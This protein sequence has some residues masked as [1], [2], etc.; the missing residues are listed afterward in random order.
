[1]P[2]PAERVEELR[3]ALE[4]GL[5]VLLAAPPSRCKGLAAALLDRVESACDAT[6]R[7]ALAAWSGRDH[8]VEPLAIAA[9]VAAALHAPSDVRTLLDL[10]GCTDGG[11]VCV[12]DAGH[13][14]REEL[15]PWRT[16]IVDYAARCSI[17]PESQRLGICL[18]TS[19]EHEA[20]RS[21]TR[22]PPALNVQQLDGY[23]SRLD[24]MSWAARHA[25]AG[26]T[27]IERSLRIAIA[28]AV[29]GG[30]PV[31]G[32]ALAQ[33]RLSDLCR[34]EKVAPVIAQLAHDAPRAEAI[35]DVVDGVGLA[36]PASL[37]VDQ[38]SRRIW[39]GQVAVVFPRLEQ[40]R[41]AVVEALRVLRQA[42]D[43]ERRRI[44]LM[45]FRDLL[46]ALRGR[47]S[48]VAETARASLHKYVRHCKSV[49]DEIAHLW[50]L[51]VET[52]GPERLDPLFPAS[53][54][55]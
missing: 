39:E 22:A 16:F 41:A 45:E 26:G 48:G 32:A 7:A 2:G 14:P 12:L 53:F 18:I 55:R 29:A 9:E 35:V 31:C 23:V 4:S 10:A 30:D 47:D 42:G 20:D 11:G 34:A 54:T 13:L 51:P 19:D 15:P 46:D 8:P 33:E 1:M 27:P 52:L 25:A 38:L 5:N 3:L 36:D 49:R 44:E 28:A 6:P 37:S 24:M 50:P 43:A 40:C 17:R 21:A